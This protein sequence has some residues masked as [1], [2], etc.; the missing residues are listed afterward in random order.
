[1][2]RLASNTQAYPFLGI[3]NKLLPDQTPDPAVNTI[4]VDQLVNRLA[5]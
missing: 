1:M 2:G 5:G 4:T 3:T